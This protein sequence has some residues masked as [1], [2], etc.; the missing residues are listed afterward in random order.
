MSLNTEELSAKKCKCEG[1]QKR[2]ESYSS[3]K[4]NAKLLLSS[5][6]EFRNYIR[7]IYINSPLEATQRNET[8]PIEENERLH[9]MVQV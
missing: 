4:K 7:N 3:D 8:I 1:C 2:Y 9:E 6:K 5:W